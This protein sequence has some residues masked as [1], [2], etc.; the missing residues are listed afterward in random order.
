MDD[1]IVIVGGGLA[2]GTAARTLRTEG[3]EGRIL[4]YAAEQH[5]PYQ[6]PPLSKEFL[7]GAKDLDVAYL[8]AEGWEQENGVELAAGTAVYELDP[9]AHEVVLENG[10]RIRY[11]ALLLAT[12]SRPRRPAFDGV[13]AA[14]VHLLRTIEDSETLKAEL[15][16]GGRRVVII[17]SGWIGLEAAAAARGYGN[18]VVVLGRE[19]IPLA[20]VLGERIGSL[21]AD[22][23]RA[24]GVDLRGPVDVVGL[25]VANGRVTGVQTADGT[26]DA[27]VVVIGVGA[28]PNTALAEDAGIAVQNGVLVDEHLRTS[29]PDVFAAG[30]VANAYHPFV[31]TRMRNEHWNN[32]LTGGKVA[33]LSMLG[34]DAAHETVPYF[35]TDQFEIGM[36]Y[37]GYPPLARDAEVVFRGDPVS[38]EY[39]AF[40]LHEGAVVAGMNVNVWKVNAKI[41]ALITSRRVVDVARL[42]DPEIPIDEV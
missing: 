20:N 3:F 6:R 4:L 26:V 9:D 30:D 39:V 11:G 8:Q 14:G 42:T 2:G 29:A 27:D 1:P 16:P 21:F 22:V 15:A 13:H 32:A 17:G 35:Y 12:G 31:D 34:R 18:E 36:E 40:W 10:E 38:G 37:A 7:T 23:H 19:E 5:R 25:S 41:K 24:H 33:A 28:L